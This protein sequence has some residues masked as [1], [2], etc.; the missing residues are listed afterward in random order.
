[1][2]GVIFFGHTPQISLKFREKGLEKLWHDL[3]IKNKQK[4]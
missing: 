2:A 3:C 1:M 4:N